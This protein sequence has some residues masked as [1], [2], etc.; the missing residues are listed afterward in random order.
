M[1]QPIRRTTEP[2]DE[3]NNEN[4]RSLRPHKFVD[5][6]R[7]V[8][9]PSDEKA[10]HGEKCWHQEDRQAEEAHSYENLQVAV[11]HSVHLALR[12]I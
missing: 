10:F 11:I 4:T 1:L 6:R 3:Q 2:A 5:D 9:W 12:L 7:V 8:L